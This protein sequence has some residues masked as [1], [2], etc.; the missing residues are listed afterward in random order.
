[1][2]MVQSFGFMSDKFKAKQNWYLNNK[3]VAK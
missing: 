3:F 2:A 1:M